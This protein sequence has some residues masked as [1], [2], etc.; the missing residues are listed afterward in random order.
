MKSINLSGSLRENVGKSDSNLLRAEG[1]VPC[2]L[3]GNAASQSH[4]WAHAYDLKSVLFTP[5]TFKIMLDLDGKKTHLC[6][7]G[8]PI[9]SIERRHAPC[10][11]Y[12]AGFHQGG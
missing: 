9:P 8:C 11:L 6:C 3:Y 10:R 5:E 2:V 12:V 4:F 1:K 7:Q